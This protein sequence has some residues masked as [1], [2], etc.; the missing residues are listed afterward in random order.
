M[1]MRTDDGK[2]LPDSE[3][4]RRI[5]KW[6]VWITTPIVAVA[7]IVIGAQFGWKQS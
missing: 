4:G 2:W 6:A 1:T 3:R 5:F 7:I